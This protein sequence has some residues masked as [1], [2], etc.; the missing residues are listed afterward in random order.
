MSQNDH[1]HPL[2]CGCEETGE[3]GLFRS[4]GLAALTSHQIQAAATSW[5]GECACLGSTWQV[6]SYLQVGEL[7]LCEHYPVYTFGLRESDYESRGERLR[8]LGCEVAKV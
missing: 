1:A 8:Q 4:P 7:I 3:S 2:Q 5:G 6:S